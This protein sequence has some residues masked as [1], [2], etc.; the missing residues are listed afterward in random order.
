MTTLSSQIDTP[1]P[2]LPALPLV[3]NVFALR[4]KR[5][6]LL[7]R[8]SNK[9]GDIGAFHFGPHMVPV[10]NSPELVHLALVDQGAIFEKTATVRTLGTPVLGNGVFLSEGEEHLRQRRLLA[11]LFQ[12]RRVLDYAE[13]ITTCASHLQETWKEGETI[14]LADEMMRLTR[15]GLS[16]SRLQRRYL[17][18][19]S[20][21]LICP[22]QI[23]LYVLE[24]D[25]G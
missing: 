24:E 6:E 4:N 11:P 7:L 3:G 25:C 16:R 5:L 12:Y 20:P 21:L 8:I 17:P 19:T 2:C 13:T 15:T 9:F 23:L 18:L 14:N 1:I 22:I 10:L